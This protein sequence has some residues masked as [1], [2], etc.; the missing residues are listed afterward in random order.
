[1]F[2]PLLFASLLLTLVNTGCATT[3]RNDPGGHVID[4]AINAQKKKFVRFDG[5]C[6]SACTLY[7]SVRNTCITPRASFHFHRP[8]GSSPE[9]NALALRFM[10]EQYPAWVREW[11]ADHGGLTSEWL[12]IDY[13]TAAL[14]MRTC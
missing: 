4:Y 3:I 8:Y 10:L 1:L 12:V 14:Y 5:K 13:R 7:L 11:I 9:G 6:M 2:R